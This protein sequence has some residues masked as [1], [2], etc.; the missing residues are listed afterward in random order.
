MDGEGNG[1]PLQDSFLGNPM[2]RG[3]WQATGSHKESD[4]T[5]VAQHTE[6]GSQQPHGTTEHLK[7]GQPK[8]KSARHVKYKLDFKDSIYNKKEHKIPH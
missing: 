4:T 7:R 6:Y 3:A 5:E 1:S 2:H 8:L